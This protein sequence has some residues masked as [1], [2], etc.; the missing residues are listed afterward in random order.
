DIFFIKPKTDKCVYIVFVPGT[1]H[2]YSRSLWYRF[3]DRDGKD[4]EVHPV[5]DLQDSLYIVFY[6]DFKGVLTI[7]R[8]Q[9]SQY[10]DKK[11]SPELDIKRPDPGFDK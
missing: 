6:C 3:D 1:D 11:E 10:F 7:N 2:K 4:Q 8:L 5:V 9:P